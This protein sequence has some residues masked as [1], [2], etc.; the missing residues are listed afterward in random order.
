M[1]ERSTGL[2]IIVAGVALV[3]VGLLVWAGA[4]N[5]FGRLP[6]DIRVGGEHTRVY[7]P[8]VSMLLLSLLLSLAVYLL[9]RFF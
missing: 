5:W 2:L 7:V 3:F 6:G 4:L 1:A 8:L 9:R